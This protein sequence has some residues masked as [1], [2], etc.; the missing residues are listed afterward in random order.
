MGYLRFRS[1]ALQSLALLPE[2]I[3]LP[4]GKT[5]NLLT[6][7]QTKIKITLKK[8]WLIKQYKKH[9]KT[10][11]FIIKATDTKEH[12]YWNNETGWQDKKSAD[13]FSDQEK[14]NLPTFSKKVYI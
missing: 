1:N 5:K 6:Y 12:L 13:I 11:L 4:N 8:R 3:N 14:I 10:K 2:K 7:S 9:Y